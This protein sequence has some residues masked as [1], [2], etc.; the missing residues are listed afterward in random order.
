MLAEHSSD[1]WRKT[2]ALCN[3]AGTTAHNGQSTAGRRADLPANGL[4]ICRFEG[5]DL[6]V[7]RILGNKFTA[8]RIL[9]AY[10]RR[11]LFIE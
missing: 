1:P 7:K 5:T 10:V 4:A 11:R 2:A 9:S 3:C 8:M 6:A